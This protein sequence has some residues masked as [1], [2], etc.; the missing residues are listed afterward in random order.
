M[1][2]QDK[3]NKNSDRD[4]ILSE[5]E[6]RINQRIDD[7]ARA[8]DETTQAHVD[9]IYRAMELMN[10]KMDVRGDGIEKSMQ[11]QYDR[12]ETSMQ[13]QYDG[14]EKSM[15]NHYDRLEKSMQNH[16]DRLEKSMQNHY[17]GLEKS[18]QT[19]FSEVKSS[20]A[21]LKATVEKLGSEYN[22]IRK[23]MLQNT[24]WLVGTLI[25]ITSVVIAAFTFLS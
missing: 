5:M 15:Q 1:S 13:N 23:E 8:H 19:Q 9:G 21:E 24:L 25:A 20:I 12:L 10:E 18:M 3:S 2:D 4:T 17:D 22:Q 11:N 7:R 14:L 16:Y 6:K